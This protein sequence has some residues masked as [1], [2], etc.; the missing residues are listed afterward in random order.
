MERDPI[1]DAIRR[2]H[3]NLS[4]DLGVTP[5]SLQRA[6]MDGVGEIAGVI[7]ATN[8]SPQPGPFDFFEAAP[9]EA[10]PEERERMI[11]QAMQADARLTRDMAAA[12]IDDYTTD[13]IYLST[14]YQVALRVAETG[15]DHD[16]LHLSIKRID[17][18]PIRDWRALQSIKNA[19]VGEEC[20]AF[21]LYPAE[22][23]LVDTA[24][25][26]HLWAFIDPTVRVPIGFVHRLVDVQPVGK[27][28]QRK[29]ETIDSLWPAKA[30]LASS[31]RRLADWMRDNTGPSD[32]TLD[33]LKEAVRLLDQVDRAERISKAMRETILPDDLRAEI[34][35]VGVANVIAA[36][37][38]AKFH[39]KRAKYLQRTDQENR[40]RLAELRRILAEDPKLDSVTDKDEFVAELDVLQGW[41]FEVTELPWCEQC[42]AY[43][44]D[45]APHIGGSP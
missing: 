1:R 21:E 31:L 23:R 38:R 10:S 14:E 3:R 27:S 26:Y 20:E 36:A 45:S 2:A 37:R 44:H 33:I 28:Q 19:I 22:S 15:W 7:V 35:R 4:S 30:E 25:Q 34:E 11:N 5:E 42:K 8:E 39:A 18:E 32:G 41:E 16:V 17:R 9:V 13:Q 6:I 40:D 29:F 24:N 12:V 43:H